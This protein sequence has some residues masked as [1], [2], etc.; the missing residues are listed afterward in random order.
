MDGTWQGGSMKGR[1]NGWTVGS[2]YCLL[3]A[4]AGGY[5]R[6]WSHDWQEDYQGWN[7]YKILAWQIWQ[8]RSCRQVAEPPPPPPGGGF[9]GP[10]MGG[11]P[12]GG[13]PM[14]GP[15]MGGPPMGGPPMGGPPSMGGPMDGPPQGAS[16]HT[17][18]SHQKTKKH[19]LHSQ[20]HCW[21]FPR[22]SLLWSCLGAKC[23]ISVLVVCVE[24][25]H[26][27]TTLPETWEMSN[28]T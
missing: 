28:P 24:A 19:L 14:G 15:P 5:F 20:L 13:P 6:V 2:T 26:R 27:L 16:H 18:F 8:S 11:P 4:G 7:K 21:K 25:Q 10:P 12:M 17:N 22:Q 3:G 23:C 9:G 1:W